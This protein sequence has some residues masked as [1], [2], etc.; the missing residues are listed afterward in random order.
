MYNKVIL[1][2]RVTAPPQLRYTQSGKSVA[3]FSIAVNRPKRNNMQP[4]LKEPQQ[5]VDF[6]NIVAWQNLA[7]ICSRYL[8]KGKLICIDGRLQ[9]RSYTGNDGQKRTACEVIANDM[10]MLSSKNAGGS[11]LDKSFDSDSKDF[12]Q[13]GGSDFGMDDDLPF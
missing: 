12:D 8:D 7:E 4:E 5:D 3:S 9:I 10:R 6:I 2:G 11:E 13:M 1:I